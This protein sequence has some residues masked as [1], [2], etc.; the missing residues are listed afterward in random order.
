MLTRI[1][2]FPF[3]AF[4][5]PVFFV[6]HAAA[7]H[8]YFIPGITIGFLLAKYLLLSG[9]LFGVFYWILRSRQKAALAS[10]SLLGLFFLFGS[11]HNFLKSIK[12]FFFLSRYT[13]LLPLLLVFYFG[14]LYR[15]SK[16]TIG[17]A[18]VRYLNVALV[19]FLV[20]DAGSIAY[21][22]YYRPPAFTLKPCATCDQPDVY[23]IVVDGYA[24]QDQLLSDFGFSNQGFLDSL[25][26]LGFQIGDHSVSN[27]TRTEYSMSSLLNMEYHNLPDYE[28]TPS[29]LNYCFS[30]IAQN[31]VVSGF[32]SA[33]Y[34]FVNNSIFDIANKPAAVRNIFS[35]SGAD[36]IES[37]TL[38]GRIKRDIYVGFVLKYGQKTP[39]Y[40]KL[41]FE[42]YEGD[43]IVSKNL[44]AEARTISA[45]PRFIYTHLLLT[46][47][48]YFYDSTGKLNPLSSIRLDNYVNKELYLNNLKGVNA[49]LLILLR[50]VRQ[51]ASKNAL[52]FLVSD[53]GFRYS[54]YPER[55]FSTLNAISYPGH[56]ENFFRDSSSGVNQFRIFFNTLFRQKMPLLED[57]NGQVPK[58]T[59]HE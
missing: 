17:A 52:I 56:S 9:A 29:R 12:L 38:F 59:L 55:C 36:L 49:K 14:L 18:V 8:F 53:H 6:L 46:H 47:F 27:Y 21:K 43:S 7:E 1:K 4:L 26:N 20:I 31:K 25:Q 22:A 41:L 50:G 57:R 51:N 3:F 34:A 2:D 15:I 42:Y 13:V 24:G 45:K 39:L 40:K 44:L 10:F 19:A 30:R 16:K 35:V 5:L 23:F 33:G 54:P 58:L 37:Q 28:V 32:E 48:P 11:L